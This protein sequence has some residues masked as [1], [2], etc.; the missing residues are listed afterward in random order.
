VIE[1]NHLKQGYVSQRVTF[2]LGIVGGMRDSLIFACLR[3]KRR[4]DEGDRAGGMIGRGKAA[5]R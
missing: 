1:M 3:E 5:G 4:R 2:A